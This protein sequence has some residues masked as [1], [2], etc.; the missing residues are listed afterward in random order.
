MSPAKIIEIPIQ[1]QIRDKSS[2]NFIKIST[3]QNSFQD[4]K[5]LYDFRRNGEDIFTSP[6]QN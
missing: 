5:L 1:E 2:T 4:H 3:R 6:N